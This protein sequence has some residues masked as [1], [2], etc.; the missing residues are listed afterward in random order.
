MNTLLG[1]FLKVASTF[2]FTAM[3]TIIKYVSD[4]YPTGQIVFF[5]SFF[6]LIPLLAWL[7]WR[8]DLIEAV[9]THRPWGHLRRSICGSMAMFC[10]FTALGYLPLPDATA[11]GYATPLMTTALAAIVLKE[12][13]RHYRW[14]AL[15][16]GFIGMLVMLTPYFGAGHPTL[17]WSGGPALG[18]L[19]GLLGTVFSAI[20]SIEV[21]KLSQVEKTGA[22][23]FYFSSTA[24]L[25]GASTFFFGWNS[26]SPREATLLIVAGICGGVGQILLTASYRFAPVSVI[27]PFDYMALLWALIVGFVM[28]SDVPQTLV[29]LGAGLVVAAGLFVI[30]RERQLGIEMRREREAGSHRQA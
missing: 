23:V 12:R 14:S 1:I 9:R 10:G 22:I 4:A 5:R 16:V 18:A 8:G 13:V 28:F 25:L 26:P 6:A 11:I 21:R 15:V 17:S 7:A 24:A 29:L 20:S 19:F 30:W 3:A 27:A 2:A